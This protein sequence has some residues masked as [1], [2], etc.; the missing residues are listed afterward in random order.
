VERSDV[1]AVMAMLTPD[2]TYTQHG[3]TL[4]GAQARLLQRVLPEVDPNSANLARVAIATAL[5]DIRFDFVKITRIQASAGRT[6][7][8][9]KADIRVFAAGT[10]QL[11]GFE[12]GFATDA[13]GTDW[14]LGFREVKGRWMIDSITAMRIPRNWR[15]QAVA[16][17]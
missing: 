15:L 16:S 9:G 14:S 17:P 11:G 4:G 2:V 6:T 5:R 7:R 8:M 13:S 12:A 3:V 1:N 10:I